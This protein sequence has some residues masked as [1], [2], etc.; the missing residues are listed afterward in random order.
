MFPERDPDVWRT[1]RRWILKDVTDPTLMEALDAFESL[2]EE[3]AAAS[4][5]LRRGELRTRVFAAREAVAAEHGLV[6]TGCRPIRAELAVAPDGVARRERLRRHVLACPG[7][8]AWAE[9]VERQRDA[10]HPRVVPSG[11]MAAPRDHSRVRR[12]VAAVGISAVAATAGYLGVGALQGGTPASPEAPVAA[13][14]ADAPA[15][16]EEPRKRAE[17]RGRTR[18]RTPATAT[19]ATASAPV[20]A[21]SSPPPQPQPQ[22]APSPAPE[23]NA[24]PG[25]AEKPGKAGKAGKAG[26]Q[27]KGH[28]QAAKAG[29]FQASPGTT[30]GL[31]AVE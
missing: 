23:R 2:P 5:G 21:S 8:A 25:K 29:G 30:G 20:T 24:K 15:A 26:K 13:A 19:T 7:C 18:D 16:K 4:L 22:P 17:T 31:V 10:T 1:R 12:A 6:F 28:Q 11:G 3:E 9:E 27:P 14:A